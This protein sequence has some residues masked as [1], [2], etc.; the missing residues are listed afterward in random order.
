MVRDAFFFQQCFKDV[1]FL[2]QDKN[3]MSFCFQ[4]ADHISKKVKVCR[5]A[6]MEEEFH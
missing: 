6:E 4:V 2:D 5:M 3:L 1:L